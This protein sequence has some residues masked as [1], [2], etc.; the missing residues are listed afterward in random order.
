MRSHWLMQLFELV[1]YFYKKIVGNKIVNPLNINE[2]MP[3]ILFKIVL[4]I[5]F[6]LQLL[7][8]P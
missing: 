6:I 2:K 5:S 7:K 3:F 8:I 4:N 1:L